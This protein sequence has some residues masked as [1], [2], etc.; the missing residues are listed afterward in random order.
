M[1]EWSNK[2]QLWRCQG[3]CLD[4]LARRIDMIGAMVDM[5]EV[6]VTLSI[7][8]CGFCFNRFMTVAVVLI[9]WLF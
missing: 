2:F 7:A 9:L 5:N 8:S 3:S 4:Y 6:V 1:D